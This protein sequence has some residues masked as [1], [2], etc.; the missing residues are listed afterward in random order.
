MVRY[1]YLH[2]VGRLLRSVHRLLILTDLQGST[3]IQD[4]QLGLSL[5]Q[6]PFVDELGDRG[7]RFGI[8]LRVGPDS[9]EVQLTLLGG[10]ERIE[11]L[12]MNSVE[13]QF[14]LDVVGPSKP[15]L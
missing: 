14:S 12:V 10:E 7:R 13:D 11:L 9:F 8:S 6:R 5:I 2:Y 4:C 15:L 1:Q 3:R